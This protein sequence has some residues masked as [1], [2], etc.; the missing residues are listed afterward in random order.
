MPGPPFTYKKLTSYHA[1]E[2]NYV[3]YNSIITSVSFNYYYSLLYYLK[4]ITTGI[5]CQ[6]ISNGIRY[7][8]ISTG[9]KY[10]LISNGIRYAVD[11]NWNDMYQLISNGIRYQLISTGI[12]IPVDF[13]W[14]QI[15]SWFQLEWYVPVDFKWNQIPVDYNW[16]PIPVDYNWNPIPVDIN[17]DQVEPVGIWNNPMLAN[18]TNCQLVWTGIRSR[19]SIREWLIFMGGGGGEGCSIAQWMHEPCTP[20]PRNINV[21]ISTP[22]NQIPVDFNWNKIPVAFNWDKFNFFFKW[23]LDPVPNWKLLKFPYYNN[24]KFSIG[25]TNW[26]HL[27]VSQLDFRPG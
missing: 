18:R 19:A 7:Q 17:W 20:T 27:V 4:L 10:Q 24:W 3:S 1:S 8:L 22:V 5:K 12:K 13:K 14:N 6:L 25:N 15:C 23:N 16:N 26:F 21:C 2:S 9:I 11:F